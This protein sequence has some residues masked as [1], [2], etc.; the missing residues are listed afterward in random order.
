[1]SAGKFLAGFIVGGAIG[2]IAGV[3]LNAILPGKD[4]EFGKDPQADKNRGLDM[5]FMDNK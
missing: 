1:M 3:L 2:A 4:Y 5:N